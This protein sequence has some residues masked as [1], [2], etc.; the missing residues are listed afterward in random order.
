M[1][2]KYSLGKKIIKEK[3]IYPDSFL[4]SNKKGDYLWVK[5]YPKSRY[6]GWFC[7]LSNNLYKIIESIEVEDKGDLL[8]IENRFSCIEKKWK[9]ITET[10][11]LQSNKNVFSYILSTE[12]QIKIFLDVR[13]SYSSSPSAKFDTEERGD[14]LIL[15]FD[16][17]IYLAVK[18]KNKKIIEDKI[19]RYYEYDKKR[20]SPP[21]NREVC[22]GISLYGKEFTFIVT[23][24][25]EEIYS[26]INQKYSEEALKND[27][28][29][30][31]VMCAK[32]SLDNLIHEE[33]PGVFAGLP[34]FFHFWQRDEA[35]SLKSVVEINPE[36]GKKIIFRLLENYN[37]KGPR[38]VVNADAIGWIFQ[39]INEF[40]YIFNSKEKSIIKNYLNKYIEESLWN[41][42]KDS[43]AIT[44]LYETWMDTLDRSGARI[45]IQAMRLNAYSLASV[46]SIRS[47]EREIYEKLEIELKQKTRDYF[48]DGTN[49]FDGYLP[50]EKK[51]DKKI[52]PNIFI[53]AYIYPS[54]LT[55]KEWCTVFD[56]ALKELWLDWGGV[57]SISIKDINFHKTH[58][59]ENPESYHQGDSWFF[60][61]N[62]TAIVLYHF[63]K[64]KYRKYI[65]KILDASEEEIL[66]KGAIGCHTEVS[67]AE[68]LDSNGCV[69]QAWSNAMYLEAKR[70]IKY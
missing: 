33:S 57:S 24:S 27:E 56:N 46:L 37:E 28:K 4:I 22:F 43:F 51:L 67:S 15:K 38:G 63:N 1:K 30:V 55:E 19:S 35:I 39:R 13:E 16:N 17:G 32:K 59:G 7:R 49:L 52:T 10:F 3:E 65:Q 61:N 26:L 45:E 36:I 66:W 8:E 14:F 2:I 25:K 9:N 23:Q 54:L 29:D 58:T 44:K 70:E 5:D 40:I 47:K 60:I 68:S 6:E 21:F 69:N 53:A 41:S 42:T 34:W 20:N 64:K 48:F 50:K 18:G 11:Y 62:L 12:K 31:S